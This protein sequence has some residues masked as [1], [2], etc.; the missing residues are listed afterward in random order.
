MHMYQ[1]VRDPI[2]LKYYSSGFK[3][4]IRKPNNMD[5]GSE[6]LHS[7]LKKFQ[8]LAASHLSCCMTHASKLLQSLGHKYIL[9]RK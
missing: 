7:S 9:P 1:T 6:C 2:L 3:M 4:G 8:L 5:S